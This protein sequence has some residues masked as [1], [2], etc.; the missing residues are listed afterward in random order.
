MKSHLPSGSSFWVFWILANAIGAT[1]GYLLYF[2]VAFR[3]RLGGL[4]AGLIIGVALIGLS[5]GIA[6]WFILAK[7]GYSNAW[8]ILASTIG[9]ASGEAV[10]RVL[11][12]YIGPG[13]VVPLED[14]TI[15]IVVGMLQ[16][17]VLRRWSR[18]A[19]WWILAYEVAWVISSNFALFAIGTL[20][21][22]IFGVITGPALMWLLRQST[23]YKNAAKESTL[24]A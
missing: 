19:G 16:V 6:Q 17:L 3:L 9:W 23:R 5:L 1:A 4:D 7:Y 20:A 10:A 8:W 22:I 15:G 24:S 11:Y 18:R 21:G 2:E 14:A 12:P 13:F